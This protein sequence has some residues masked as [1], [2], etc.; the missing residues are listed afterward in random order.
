MAGWLAGGEGGALSS[1][2]KLIFAPPELEP[3]RSISRRWLVAPPPPPPP[4]A[5]AERERPSSTR[6]RYCI[7]TSQNERERENSRILRGA[8]TGRQQAGGRGLF[9]ANA[10]ARNWPP[11]PHTR[12]WAN[13]SARC[14]LAGRPVA[15][16][17][18]RAGECDAVG[19][20]VSRPRAFPASP[21]ASS[22]AA[23]ASGLQ[24]GE[25][26]SWLIK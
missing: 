7:I 1:K 15:R 13:G 18:Y 14:W 24:V 10:S 6:H 2:N 3:A 21:A 5:P 9:S 4:P 16:L 20:F 11:H 17:T 19:A 22:R 26:I 8:R 12:P 23:L 25:K